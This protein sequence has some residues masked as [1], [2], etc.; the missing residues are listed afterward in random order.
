MRKPT[1]PQEIEAWYVIP[2]IRRGFVKA[3]T[4]KGLSQKEAALKLGLTGAA[5]SQYM[6]DKRGM[7]V[8]F[9]SRINAEIRKSAESLMNGG[10]AMRELQRIC[11]LARKERVVC[12]LSIKMGCK[13]KNCRECFK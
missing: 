13:P 6:S 9:S 11:N 8:K 7:D 5:V 4:G 1:S 12:R 3:M 10:N 2:A